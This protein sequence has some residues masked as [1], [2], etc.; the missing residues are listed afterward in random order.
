MF[1]RNTCKKP[2]EHEKKEAQIQ[3]IRQDTLDKIKK[4]TASIDKL[5]DLLDDPSLGTTGFI[6]YATGG[7]KRIVK[8]RKKK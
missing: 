3:A 4:A 6:F 8:S 7:D 1:F 5:N 2:A